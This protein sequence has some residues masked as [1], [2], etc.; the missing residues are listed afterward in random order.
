M[1]YFNE[2]KKRIELI[3]RKISVVFKSE[4]GREMKLGRSR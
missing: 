4:F 2:F 3:V 1:E